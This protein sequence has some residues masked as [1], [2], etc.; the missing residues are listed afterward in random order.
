MLSQEALNKDF[1]NENSMVF[2]AHYVENWNWLSVFNFKKIN[3]NPESYLY[4][5]FLFWPIYMIAS[6]F[7]M[8]GKKPFNI[9][10]DFNFKHIRCQ[11]KALRNFGWHFFIPK[12]RDT[13]R[14]RI[15]DSILYAQE[16][17]GVI[18]LG[19]LTKDE[20]ITKGGQWII[21]TLGD[22]LKV[23]LVHG[24]TLT[25]AVVIEQIINTYEHLSMSKDGSIFLI[26]STS[27]IGRAISLTLAENKIKVKMFTASEERFNEI[28][29][30]AGENKI[31]LE[32]VS[33][34]SEG[35]DSILWVTGKAIPKGNELIK[36]IPKNAIVIN[37]AVPNPVSERDKKNRK[38]VI[39]CN[40]GI[41]NYN[42]KDTNIHMN[43]RLPKGSIYACHAG[44]IV[45]TAC[46]WRHHEVGPVDLKMVPVVFS[47]AI[48]LGFTIPKLVN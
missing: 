20:K 10:D 24:D 28:R 8:F 13:I 9:I 2:L 34:L 36:Y 47:E 38:D 37:F 7:Y 29:K 4:F 27:K 19:A 5:I 42:E 48:K 26:G 39:F 3:E 32:K 41:L 44:T 16:K 11:T 40:G 21:E 12:Y 45:H 23:P 17:H 6:I 15:I 31:F 33:S 22:K 35:K 14:K 46:G 18:G 1:K 30:E 43:M 25:A